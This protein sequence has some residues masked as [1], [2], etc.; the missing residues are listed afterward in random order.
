[1]RVKLSIYT[2]PAWELSVK[3]S[4][5]KRRLV[6]SSEYTDDDNDDFS[7]EI[8]LTEIVFRTREREKKRDFS[9]K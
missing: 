8:K 3:P 2:G 6:L 5:T 9:I 1:M 7:I 4:R